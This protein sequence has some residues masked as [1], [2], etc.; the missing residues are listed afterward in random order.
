MASILNL[1]S[2]PVQSSDDPA[3][4]TPGVDL[5]RT[6]KIHRA[7][8]LIIDDD[9]DLIDL[10]KITLRQ[11]GFDVAS[12]SDSESALTQVV[13][14]NPD[15]ILLDLMM[16]QMDGW[17]IYRQ[18]RALTQALVIV[19][20]ASANQDYAV[21][22]LEMGAQDYITKPFYNPEMIARINKVLQR[23]KK[24][25]PPE[26]AVFPEIDLSLDYESHEIT[27]RGQTTYLPPSEFNFLRILAEAAPKCV[28]GAA[29]ASQLWGEDSPQHRS[30]IKNIV[31][32]LRQKV[33]EN[34]SIPRLIVNY[35]GLGYQLDTRLRGG[36][37]RKSTP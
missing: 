4:L 13:E 30:H 22:S 36:G 25:K 17:S 32:L 6:Q 19:I 31:F 24:G 11:A 3:H 34:P 20:S 33:E 5:D 10:L 29:I 14:V 9:V 23:V 7:R 1:S 37:N 15:A 21:R 18:L 26:A 2:N 28:S 8:I 35:R 12:A 16:P 27:L